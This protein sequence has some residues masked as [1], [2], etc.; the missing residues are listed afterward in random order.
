MP[1]QNSSAPTLKAV[2]PD[3][4]VIAWLWSGEGLAWAKAH[5]CNVRHGRGSFAEVKLDHE[6]ALSSTTCV[7]IGGGSPYPDHHIRNDLKRY[8]M[9]GVPEEWRTRQER[10]T[11]HEDNQAADGAAHA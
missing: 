2:P 7:Y 5:T 4:E 11:G 8:G 9:S 6:C 3:P 10:C 1:A